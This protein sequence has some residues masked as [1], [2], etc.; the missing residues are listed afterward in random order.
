LCAFGLAIAADLFAI[1]L[2]ASAARWISKPALMLLLL[3]LVA[4][5]GRLGHTTA[6]LLGLGLVLAWAADIALLVDG[7][8]AFLT[9]MALFGLMQVCYLAV[10]VRLGALQHLR[11]RWP[12]PALYLAL[13]LAAN[14]L[15]WPRLDALAAPVAVYSLLLVAMGAVAV[16]VNLQAALGGALF[17][18]SDLVLGLGV[19]GIGMPL[20]GQ[21]VMATYA[22]AQ[23]LIVLGALRLI[24]RPEHPAAN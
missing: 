1:S 23:L 21:T 22:A 19:A 7:T 13:W 5:S 8:P 2:D 10:F 11:R 24:P 9:G 18:A 15:L 3:A 17:V 4:V 20:Q 14:I 6:R 12:A 16:G